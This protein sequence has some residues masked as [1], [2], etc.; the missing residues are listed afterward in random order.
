MASARQR[1][2]TWTA[3]WRLPDGS[4]KTKGGFS[5]E[6][7]AL[8]AGEYTEAPANPPKA[9]EIYL[10]AKKGKPTVSGFGRRRLQSRSC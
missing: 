4:Q 3:Y 7:K 5:T 6:E 1:G 8:K 2:K 9:I 10:V